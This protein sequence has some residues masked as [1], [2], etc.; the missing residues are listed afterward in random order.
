MAKQSY[1]NQLV[2]EEL[3]A[4]IADMTDDLVLEGM[5]RV[6]ARRTA[7]ETFGHIDAIEQQVCAQHR[8]SFWHR[9]N[10]FLVLGA[11]YLLIALTFVLLR[12]AL[13]R[14]VNAARLEPIMLWWAF[15]GITAIGM[16]CVHWISE[17]RGYR[18]HRFVRMVFLFILLLSF[19]ITAV[20]D[21]DNFEVNLH[22]ILFLLMTYVF[23]RWR[24]E[25][26]ALLLKR[27]L[28]FGASAFVIWMTLL[29]RPIFQFV[30][31]ARCLFLTPDTIPLTGALAKCQQVPLESELLLPIYVVLIIGIPTMVLFW[32]HYIQNSATA[33]Y[34]K[35]AFSAVLVAMPVTPTLVHNVNN[36]GE[37]DIVPWK[38]Q[39]YFAYEEVLGRAP[40][41]KDIDF[42]AVTAS[43]KNMEKVRDVLYASYERQLKIDLL[44]QEILHRHA[45]EAEGAAYIENRKSVKQI[46]AELREQAIP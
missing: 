27:A 25:Q 31:T 41:Q 4:H 35:I 8:Q 3:E 12:F 16:M 29:E 7:E 28:V 6:I 2:R 22:A 33:L 19:S 40:E 11:S 43:Y 42:Y 13:G 45:T 5:E 38:A 21:I 34:R 32:S 15:V 24:W 39:I 20:L 30:G 26:S 44:Y 46:E 37:L 9:A 36:Y 18:D 1:H 14:S 23:L 17:Y 10:P